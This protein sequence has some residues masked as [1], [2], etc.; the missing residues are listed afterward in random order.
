MTAAL[1][2]TGATWQP[3]SASG[4]KALEPLRPGI[5]ISLQI[6]GD[7]T[8]EDLQFAQQLGVEYV[9]IPSG[10]DKATYETFARLKTR[11][12]SAGLKVW[13]I[14]NSNVHNM[15]EVTL[16]L[17]GRDQKIEE[18]KSYL[19]NLAKAGIFYTTYAHMGN[20]IWS[21][22]RE[23]TRGRA[24]ARA[25][26]LAKDPKGYWAGKVFEGP[27]SHER[28]YTADELWDN[29]RYFIKQVVP[30]AEELGMRIGIHPDDPPVPELAGV[31]RCI[32]GNFDGYVRAMEMA[33]SPNIG[34]CLCAGTWMEGGAH[35]GKDVFEAAR[36]FAK[37]DKLWKIHFRNV[38]A[39]IPHFV[40]TFVD[41]GYTDMLRLMKTL[42]EVDFRG[43]V[44]ADHVPGM[45]GGPRTGWA[46]SIGYIK[47]L[48]RSVEA[49]S[50]QG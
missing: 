39:P 25:F 5:K 32:F 16:N 29:Y 8:D 47:G 4:A 33:N 38:S 49:D 31:P 20:G 15:P 13:N 18:Y 1:A 45:V 43:V 46:Y 40:E 12:D 23:M 44:I 42:H 3:W 6:S 10:G 28:R 36:A 34:V 21:S 14:G 19:R 11:V 26:D 27:L 7:A 17:P 2:A 24:P 35:M 48:L 22:E 9:S 41:N 30:V 37:M 50:K